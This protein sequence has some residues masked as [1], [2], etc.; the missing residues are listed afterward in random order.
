MK[1]FWRRTV[2]LVLLVLSLAITAFAVKETEKNGSKS[3]ADAIKVNE[4]VTGTTSKDDVDFFKFTL[5]K[6]GYISIDFSHPILSSTS[7]YWRI[8]LYISD[9][10]SSV[11]GDD[12]YWSV[13]GNTNISTAQIGLPA[14][15]FY[16]KLVPESSNRYNDGQYTLRV[17]YEESDYWELERNG[18]MKKADPLLTNTDYHGSIVTRVDEDWYQ[19]TLEEAGKV[20]LQ[21]THPAVSSTSNY[22]RIYFYTSDGVTNADGLSDGYYWSVKGNENATLPEIGLPAGTYYIKITGESYN[23]YDSGTYTLRANYEASDYWESEINNGMQKADPIE[24][25]TIY[26]GSTVLQDEDWFKFELPEDGNVS[27]NFKHPIIASTSHYWNI[28]LY[29]ADGVTSV[30]GDTYWVVAGN[31]NITTSAIGLPAGT[32][33]IKITP[34]SYHNCDNGTYTLQVNYEQSDRW[35]T[36]LNNSFGTADQLP[37]NR[38]FHGVTMREDADWFRVD[39]V[40]N[41]EITV[42]FSHTYGGDNGTY[43][44]IYL[45]H[46]DGVTELH[47]SVR[48]SGN[49]S[50][51]EISLGSMEVGVYYIKI[52]PESYNRYH[53]GVYT[54]HV[55]E[56]HEHT[57]SSW[58]VTQEPTCNTPGIRQ[59]TCV[60]CDNVITEEIPATGHNLSDWIVEKEATC[61]EDGKEIQTCSECTVTYYRK[62]PAT[63]HIV[64]SWETTTRATCA[65]SGERKGFCS[66][67]E[68]EVTEELPQL[69]HSYGVETHLSG[70]IVFGPRVYEHTCLS[71]GYVEQYEDNTFWFVLPL[72]I[73]AAAA[74]VTVTVV[75]CVRAYRK[76]VL[77]TTFVCPFCFETHKLVDVQFRCSNNLCK[78]VPDLEMTR[79]EQGNM[80]MPKRGKTT[81]KSGYIPKSMKDIPD[82]ATCPVC[83]RVTHKI[84]CPSCHN[85]L[86][87]STLQGEDMIISIVGSR[88]SG[89]SHFVGVIINEL[90]ERIAPSF[91]GSFE[92]F[93]DTT[94]RYEQTFGQKLYVDLRKLDLTQ[95]SLH[96]VNNGAYRPLIYSLKFQVKSGLKEKIVRYT[97]VFFDTAGE[98]LGDADTM[99]TVNRYICKSAG[100]IFLLDPTKIAGVATQLDQDTIDRA[101]SVGCRNSASSDDILVR[102]SN[103]IRND[104]GLKYS[105]KIPVPVAVVFSKFDA[106]APIVPQGSAVLDNSPHCAQKAFVMSDW[107]NVNTEVQG[108][109]KTWGADSFLSQ[110]AVNYV[111]YSCFVASSLGLNNNPTRDMRINRPRP[112]RIEDAL[113]WILMKKK[114]IKK[115]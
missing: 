53:S 43:W 42:K 10:T 102:V 64:D 106:V 11:I 105:D 103:L 76:K 44:N 88:D 3:K 109:L 56:K 65:Q 52:T 25:N 55:E 24:V 91:G 45:Y 99:S 29:T 59:S 115:K 16:I 85:M 39:L 9:G 94:T 40:S 62:I 38:D 19:L 27:L 66:S 72:I 84:V 93:D 15:T 28:Y 114:V 17:N 12:Y 92:G 101:S 70:N 13:P 73:L 110:L 32:Y 69:E 89:K 49:E 108:L 79:Y 71:C 47:D 83:Y 50:T 63:G 4:D 7:S 22:W 8:Y 31:E 82:S 107:H 77:K 51:T 67:C 33:Y 86:P 81:F 37:L 14:G 20:S 58:D 54:L 90:I 104:Q 57:Y 26:S 30:I 61:G 74:L 35:E 36:E 98:D 68:Q 48:I 95:S 23:N 75:C 97:L 41:A 34:E 2:L 113:L 111:D 18:S 1:Q 60:A 87:E 78:D 46:S 96:N 21:F 112:H 100:I 6:P 5:S 80:R